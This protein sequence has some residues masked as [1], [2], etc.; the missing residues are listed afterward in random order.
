MIEEYDK[1]YQEVV[2]YCRRILEEAVQEM[3]DM[4]MRSDFGENVAPPRFRII[5]PT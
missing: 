3:I 2:E 4:D 1:E 5:D